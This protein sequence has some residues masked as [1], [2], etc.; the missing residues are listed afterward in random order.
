MN[1][2]LVRYI[3]NARSYDG[4]EVVDSK[5]EFFNFESRDS[6]IN[7]WIEDRI[8]Y[9][10]TLCGKSREDPE[11]ILLQ[12][13][14]GWQAPTMGTEEYES[15]FAIEKE[16]NSKVGE[17]MNK[18]RAKRKENL[19]NACQK[20]AAQRKVSEIEAAKQLLKENGII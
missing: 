3:P 13:G 16:V 6:L 20:A 14:L 10:K 1:Y 9:E 5:L 4:E 7:F 18:Y 8:E 11:Y 19:K 17:I 15:H 2:T 12:N